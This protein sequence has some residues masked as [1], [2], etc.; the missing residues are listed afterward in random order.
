MASVFVLAS[1]FSWNA[2]I[3]AR[4]CGIDFDGIDNQR[5]VVYEFNSLLRSQNNVGIVGQHIN[6]VCINT[7]NRIYNILGAWVHRLSAGQNDI[8]A[9]T[10]Q[11]IGNAIT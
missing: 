2:R 9:Y 11:N 8:D 3:A 6:G 10:R 1:A 7:V 4:P 5:F